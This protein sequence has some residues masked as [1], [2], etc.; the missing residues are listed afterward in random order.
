[1]KTLYLDIFSGISGDMFI[2][3]MLD[4]GVN[5]R[6]F[7]KE[8][9]KLGLSGYHL[10]SK[11]TCKATIEGVKF[12]VHLDDDHEHDHHHPAEAEENY[13]GLDNDDEDRDEEQSHQHEHE[14]SHHHRESSGQHQDHAHPDHHDLESP[15]HDH[16]SHQHQHEHHHHQ[17]AHSHSHSH[18][19]EHHGRSFDEIETLISYSPLSSWVRDKSIAVFRRI[20]I[21]EGKIHGQ[22]PEKVH[23]HE[24]GAIDSIVDIVGACLP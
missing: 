16:S 21:A 4:L 17:G 13:G 11:R 23:F 8:L 20:A 7:E 14:H 6:D 9:S 3:A 12:D 15:G 19:H 1:M 2:G 22:P 10:H 5:F 24:V 18:T